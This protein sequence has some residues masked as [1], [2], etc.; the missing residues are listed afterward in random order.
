MPPM[1]A[2]EV[3]EKKKCI[4]NLDRVLLGFLS[5]NSHFAEVS[6]LQS[7]AEAALLVCRLCESH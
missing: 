6:A 2:G 5:F 7:S 4:F 3:K 1:G